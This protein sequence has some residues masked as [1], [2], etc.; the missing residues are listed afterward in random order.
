MIP[1]TCSDVRKVL[2]EAA[3]GDL[4]AEPAA[5]LAEHVS[6]CAACRAEESALGRTLGL[7]RKAA[8][9][10]ASTERRAAAVAAMSRAHADQ[11]ERL[12]TR[13]P[14]AW[15]PWATAAAF[16]LVLAAALNLRGSGASYTVSRI[17]GSANVLDREAD[18]SHPVLGGMILAVGDR[19]VT[20]PGCKLRLLSGSV[21]ICIDEDSSVDFV[22]DRRLMLDRGRLRVDV[23]PSEL[24]VIS[25]MANNSA[26]VTGRVEL[27][28]RDVEGS[29]GS[30]DEVRG[31]MPKVSVPTVVK[32]KSLVAKVQSGDI[33]LDGDRDQRLRASKGQEGTFTFGGKPETAPLQES[34]VGA[35]AD[36]L[37]EKR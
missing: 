11:A 23:P 1:M 18:F 15:I 26:R 35:W 21:E 3:L 22:Q 37:S 20:N 7:L 13:R 32:K 6:A 34:G 17:T 24:L 10:A 8:P 4:D 31:Q 14:R 2:A 27:S 33:A 29:V 9:V 28:L 36:G 19:L 25:D 12:L 5:R 30:S 16:L